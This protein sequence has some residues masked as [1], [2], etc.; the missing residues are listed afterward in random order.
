MKQLF[1]YANGYIRRCDWKDIALLKLCLAAMGVMV[2]LQVP[3]R[4]RK[5]VLAGAAVVFCLTYVPLMTGFL[6]AIAGM[7]AEKSRGTLT[8]R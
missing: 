8:G 3:P 1:D 7:R 6:S 4:R 2:G 5:S